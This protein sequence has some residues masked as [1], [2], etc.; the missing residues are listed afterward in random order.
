[1]TR[2]VWG[3]PDQIRYEAGLANGV[4]YPSNGPGVVWN[5]LVNVE[6]SFVGGESTEYHFDGVKYLETVSPKNYQA[7]L[8][9]FS[10]PEEFAI[11]VGEKSV[12]PGFVLTRQPRARF[13]L[14]YK[15]YLGN[16]RGYKLH[17]VYNAL[18]SPNSRG[19]SSTN[20]STIAGTLSWKIDA[21]PVASS[22][23]RPTAHFVMDSTKTDAQ[24]METIESL[25]Y[26]TETITPALPE[27]EV[28]LDITTLW[29]PLTIIHQ[30]VTGLSNLVPGSEDLYKTKVD[31]INRALPS[32]R[33]NKTPTSGLY[34]ME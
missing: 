18:A 24:A 1:M 27:L 15:T 11:S 19:Y 7:T 30:S 13:G 22:T 14:S 31:G 29:S 3:Q 23:F 8:T 2:L 10:A 5:G 21:V 4:L 32:T 20:A 12:I 17:L 33:L 25:L 16:D 6:E 28:L 34:R 26:G 9:A